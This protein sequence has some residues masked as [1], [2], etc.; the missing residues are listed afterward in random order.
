MASETLRKLKDRW[1]QRGRSDLAVGIACSL[2]AFVLGVI[3]T[4]ISAVK[5]DVT[6]VKTDVATIKTDVATIK[7]DVAT[8][9]ADVIAVKI[10]V[11]T[12]K[13]DVIAVKTDVA[14]IKTDV[15]TVATDVTTV[16]I[17]VATVKTDVST[18]ETQVARALPL[19]IQ[20]LTYEL[21]LTDI[22]VENVRQAIMRYDN[23][24][25]S[26]GRQQLQPDEY[27]EL[28]DELLRLRRGQESLNNRVDIIDRTQRTGKIPLGFKK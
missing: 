12:I 14:T 7:T 27:R 25:V 8:I 16:K 2:A 9:K 11:G 15:T 3:Y 28:L 18:I 5:T 24:P 23:S 1:R 19:G 22:K 13:T 6:A 20:Q 17:D 10:D 26:S 21:K 4:D